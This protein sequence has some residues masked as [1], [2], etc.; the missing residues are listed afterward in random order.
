[1]YEFL[2][3]CI[4]KEIDGNFCKYMYM[5][6]ECMIFMVVLFHDTI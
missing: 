3:P 1:M 6:H 5:I 2:L 4:W